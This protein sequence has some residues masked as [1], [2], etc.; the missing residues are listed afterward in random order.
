MIYSIDQKYIAGIVHAHSH[1]DVF[2]VV[3]EGLVVSFGSS[4]ITFTNANGNI[5][6][7]SPIFPDTH[8]SLIHSVVI[9]IS[10]IVKLNSPSLPASKS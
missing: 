4:S 2:E 9:I 8:S 10:P 1:D 3:L 7:L 6:S 5:P